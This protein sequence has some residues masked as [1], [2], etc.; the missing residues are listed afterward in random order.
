MVSARVVLALVLLTSLVSAEER[1]VRIRLQ[2]G[3]VI[4]ATLVDFGSRTYRFRING[5]LRSFTEDQIVEIDFRALSSDPTPVPPPQA[6]GA[7]V[8]SDADLRATLEAIAQRHG[9]SLVLGPS[10]RG[11]V[12]AYI[13]EGSP[14]AVIDAI[15]NACNFR[16]DEANGILALTPA[17]IELPR[18]E[19]PA[20]GGPPATLDVKDADI[21][22][23]LPLLAKSA[24]CSVVCGPSVRG[25]VTLRFNGVPAY[26]AL[27]SA[28]EAVN[29][30]LFVTRDGIL[31]VV[32]APPRERVA[33]TDPRGADAV[34]ELQR[35]LDRLVA[36]L[37]RRADEVRRT[38]PGNAELPEEVARAVECMQRAQ[39]LL[40]AGIATPAEVEEA[41]EA[42]LDAQ[43]TFGLIAPDVWA[44]AKF[45][46]LRASEARA[47]KLLDSGVGTE[48]DLLRAQFRVGQL[49][50][51]LGQLSDDEFLRRCDEALSRERAIRQAQ[52][53]ER[54]L[55]AAE[56]AASRLEMAKAGGFY[57]PLPKEKKSDA[58][59]KLVTDDFYKR[60]E[61]RFELKPRWK[62]EVKGLYGCAGGDPAGD[63]DVSVYAS[64]E[65]GEMLVFDRS[66]TR[67]GSEKHPA[68]IL[69]IVDIDGKGGAELLQIQ[70]FMFGS[71]DVWGAD[72]GRYWGR[73]L[74]RGQ[75]KFGG[76]N[77][78]QVADMDGDGDMEVIVA[79]YGGGGV[80]VFDT[81]GT[82]LYA[83][84]D[85]I[86]GICV[87]RRP[88]GKR[89]IGYH[90]G[91]GVKEL[92]YAGG[93]ETPWPVK[94][95]KAIAAGDLDGDGTDEVILCEAAEG[96]IDG[97]DF[98]V[99]RSSMDG[100]E[101]W[102]YELPQGFALREPNAIVVEDLDGDKCA[103][104]LVSLSPG[105]LTREGDKVYHCFLCLIDSKGRP[106]WISEPFE[107]VGD[108]TMGSFCVGLS[109]CDLDGDGDKE[110]ILG[111]LGQGVHVFD[112][113]R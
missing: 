96:W 87:A 35:D 75:S 22:Q 2:D 55:S 29:C 62:A 82:E 64:T 50:N 40:A 65:A 71:F 94:K 32:P 77:V 47:R 20:G 18:F 31:I 9:L 45:E 58:V 17:P 101:I 67:I 70:N 104:V 83:E 108:V 79:A 43:K 11:T 111:V 39:E 97:K 66:G 98:V 36:E 4:E 72:E 63:G 26:V 33:K 113:V 99:A 59:G 106:A 105:M 90:F 93:V 23:V 109:A 69:R 38:G 89:L 44:K 68:G 28:A 86:S 25:T 6:E 80:Q 76:L 27:E 12:S 85:D 57:R 49:E 37:K 95:A 102:K 21:R 60:P 112:V 61:N 103:E 78:P 30:G 74:W 10:V 24:G 48:I 54:T 73:K 52:F 16:V 34:A 84:D 3:S 51:V 15:S 41:R 46:S 107:G 8:V 7:L 42:L 88:L 91:G 81:D 14:R 5:E 56:L 1:R 19:P 110:A 92:A 13:P 53:D 100:K